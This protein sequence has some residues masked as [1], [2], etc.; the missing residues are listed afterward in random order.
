MYYH[1]LVEDE[2]EARNERLGMKLA[3]G[4]ILMGALFLYMKWK[5][6]K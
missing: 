1:N 4:L 3:I 2:N 6:K 5:K